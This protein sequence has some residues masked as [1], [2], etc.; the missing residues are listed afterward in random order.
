M[1]IEKYLSQKKKSILKKWFQLILK[2][3]PEETAQFI[4]KEKDPFA[5]PVGSTIGKG[6]EDLFEALQK[7]ID[8]KTV[9]SFLDPIIR[10]RAIQD[11]SP[12]RAINF[13]FL[14]KD[15]LREELKSEIQDA[16]ILRELLEFESRIDELALIA[17]DIYMKCR[18]KIY[19]LKANEI[20]DRYFRLLQ[21]ANLLTEVPEQEP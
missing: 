10:I 14:L 20:K 19:E 11:F 18:E 3:Y 1:K 15:V 7:K 21:R 5:N 17:F 4:K 13:I 8:P 12:S 2:T 6:F 16:N 9:S